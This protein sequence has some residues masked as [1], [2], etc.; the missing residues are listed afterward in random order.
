MTSIIFHENCSNLQQSRCSQQDNSEGPAAEVQLQKAFALLGQDF[1]LFQFLNGLGDHGDGT[2]KFLTEEFSRPKSWNLN[3]DLSWIILTSSLSVE[4]PFLH[5]LLKKHGTSPSSGHRALSFTS[6]A[7][8][9]DGLR[10]KMAG[11][12]VLSISEKNGLD[13]MIGRIYKLNWLYN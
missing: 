9:Q 7:R 3:L 6:W 2:S 13:A 12:G 4:F 10:W 8:W 1:Q 11:Y 5:S